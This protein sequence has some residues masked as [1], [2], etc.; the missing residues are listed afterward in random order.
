MFFRLARLDIVE[1]Y[2]YFHDELT[3]VS[4]FK[5]ASRYIFLIRVAID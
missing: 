2:S 4:H 3:Y 5:F 1:Q